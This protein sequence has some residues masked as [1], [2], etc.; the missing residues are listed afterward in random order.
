MNSLAKFFLQNK[1]LSW[2][3]LVLILIGGLFS[4]TQMGKLEDA[5]FTLKQA[6][7][8]TAYPGASSMEVQKQVTDVLE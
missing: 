7:V 6:V 1:A 2:F 5:P 3:L 4:Y 8:I